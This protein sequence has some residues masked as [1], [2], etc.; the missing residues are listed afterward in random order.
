[1]H[2]KYMCTYSVKKI[3]E[4]FKDDDNLLSI[5]FHSSRIDW[6]CPYEHGIKITFK[7]KVDPTLPELHMSVQ[8]HPLIAGY[9][10]AET[11]MQT[12]LTHIFPRAL[13][14]DDDII[15]H[16]EPED[17]F[18]HIEFVKS[19]LSDANKYREVISSIETSVEIKE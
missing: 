3:M 17:L 2:H 1:M 15:R 8:T 16:M 18:N 19:A 12:D 6:A 9:A 5:N 11:A 10:F 4:K 7:N 13:G 14:Y